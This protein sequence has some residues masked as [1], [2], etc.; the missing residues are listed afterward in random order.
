MR[1]EIIKDLLPSYIDELTSEVSNKAVKEHLAECEECRAYY[2]EMKE[3]APAILEKAG[4]EIDYFLRIREDTIRKVMIAILAVIMI[5]SVF[6]S[7]YNNL[8]GVGRSMTSNEVIVELQVIE[9]ITTLVF[10]PTDDNWYAI[11]GYTE[12]EPVDGEVPLNTLSLVKYRK[13]PFREYDHT[14]NRFPLSFREG[15]YHHENVVLN[16][17]SLPHEITFKEDDFFA[18]KFFDGTKTI[19]LADLRDGDISSLQ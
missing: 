9:G 14:A 7:I 3:Q 1:C 4:R 5:Y 11:V 17:F 15:E 6:Y 8:Y 10:E 19:T 13:N 16:L 18:V 12:N 2:E